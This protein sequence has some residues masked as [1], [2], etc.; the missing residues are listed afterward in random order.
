MA[1]RK[2]AMSMIVGSMESHQAPA[3][4]KEP[5]W[6]GGHWE[7]GMVPGGMHFVHSGPDKRTAYGEGL[8]IQ[9]PAERGKGM[10]KPFSED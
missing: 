7:P 9:L 4:K 5:R 3:L 8:G 6:G 2:M 10:R 1:K